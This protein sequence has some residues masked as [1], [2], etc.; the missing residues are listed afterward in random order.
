MLSRH[1]QARAIAGE[2]ARLLM[3]PPRDADTRDPSAIHATDAIYAIRFRAT[4]VAGRCLSDMPPYRG[5]RYVPPLMFTP[6][7]SALPDDAPLCHQPPPT[8]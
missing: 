8:I 5:E 6:P 7:S 3:P 4:C 1:A 2:A